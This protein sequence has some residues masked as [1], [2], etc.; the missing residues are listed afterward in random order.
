MRKIVIMTLI[1]IV[2]IGAGIGVYYKFFKK[3]A[4]PTPSS[5]F[6]PLG[7]AT[8]LFFNRDVALK[9]T[10]S[11]THDYV[12]NFIEQAGYSFVEENYV[13]SYGYNEISAR[14]DL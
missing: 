11:Q 5:S 13:N 12:K 2:L 7:Y 9:E 10:A 6:T 4:T 3:P 1:A 8:V 14:N